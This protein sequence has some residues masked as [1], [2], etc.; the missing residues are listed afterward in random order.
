MLLII[1]SGTIHGEDD[2]IVE[3][4]DY[5]PDGSGR[6][7]GPLMEITGIYDWDQMGQFI[8]NETLLDQIVIVI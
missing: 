4:T 8:L 7:N 3:V 5:Y 1:S 6:W 2:C